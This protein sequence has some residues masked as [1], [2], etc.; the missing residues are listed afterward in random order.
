MKLSNFRA[1]LCVFVSLYVRLVGA[2]MLAFSCPFRVIGVFRGYRKFANHESHEPHEKDTKRYEWL[3]FVRSVVRCS[4][5][6][7]ARNQ[8]NHTEPLSD[9]RTARRVEP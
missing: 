8:R 6:R 5:P 9:F 1:F 3:A 2:L 7:N 4:E